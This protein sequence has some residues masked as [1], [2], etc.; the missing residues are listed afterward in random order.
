MKL[1]TLGLVVFVIWTLGT[2]LVL[3]DD[4]TFSLRSQKTITQWATE[5]SWRVWFVFALVLIG[6]LGLLL[7]LLTFRE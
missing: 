3:V 5:V 1:T 6:P 2:V 7:H 4:A